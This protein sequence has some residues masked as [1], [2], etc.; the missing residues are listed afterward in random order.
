[1]D[2]R[3]VAAAASDLRRARVGHVLAPMAALAYATAAAIALPSAG[4]LTTYRTG[5][6]AAAALDLTAGFGLI[7]AGLA[8]IRGGKASVLGPL[9]LLAGL[10]WFGAD[11]EGWEGGPDVVRVVGMAIAPVAFA[12]LAHLVVA[13]AGSLRGL[14]RAAVVALYGVMASVG[15]GGL[16]V[17]DPYVDVNCWRTCDPN[18]LLVH[19]DPALASALTTAERICW[20]AAG[21]ALALLCVARLARARAPAR[22][23]LWPVQLGGVLVG[24]AWAV[25]GGV[26]LFGPI[27][28][29]SVPA[30]AAAFLA[31]T[32]AAVALA[33]GLGI[34]L[35]EALRRRLTVARLAVAAPPGGLRDVLVAAVADPDLQIAYRVGEGSR[36]VSATGEPV[37]AAALPTGRAATP[38]LRGGREVARVI[39]DAKS[40]GLAELEGELGAASRLAFENEALSAETL[41]QMH[42][43][44]ASRRR[45]VQMG[46][47]ERRSLERDLHDGAQQRL[48][49][50][51][52]D[53]R[54]ASVA[55]GERSD[56]RA[57]LDLA[58]D[59]AQRSLELLR[60]LAHGIYP[61]I[62]GEAGLGAA[63][64]T[65]ADGARIP[66][67]LDVEVE[68]RVAAAAETAAYLTVL[69][70]VETA[71]SAGAAFAHVRA[72]RDGGELIVEIEDDAPRTRVI[73][74]V[75]ADR[76][77]TLG[78]TLDWRA[79]SVRAVIPC[80]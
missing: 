21:M 68:D 1:V 15:V 78:G 34:T 29:P 17:R 8:T 27:E 52:Y 24:V 65:F 66:V 67:E 60:E 25:S 7:V 16:L 50:L 19:S 70:A 35:Y 61:A 53:L 37:E 5:S 28:N 23:L 31:R 45:I 69:E 18:P 62:L 4:A 54:V 80:A 32:V 9:A 73:R 44:R 12:L 42:D 36:Y 39:H 63:L 72:L 55:A 11:W 59:E 3:P 13:A 75:V 6:G 22:R 71:A 43:L 58:G 79:N 51:S 33:V 26:L 49:A 74:I 40:P 30:D 14:V 41:S 48:L 57:L 77:G 56:V 10:A 2:N 76:I 38:I 46:D 20:L 64:A 47:A